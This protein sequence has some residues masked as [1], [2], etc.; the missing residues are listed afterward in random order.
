MGWSFMG[1]ELYTAYLGMRARQRALDVTANNIANVSTTAFK[2]DRLLYRSVEAATI[3]ASLLQADQNAQSA[4]PG[5]ANVAPNDA[6]NGGTVDKPQVASIAVTLP[7]HAR[8]VGVLMSTATDFSPGPIRQTG[9]SLDVALEGDGFLVVQTPRGER[10]TRAGALTLNAN[11]QL[12]THQGDLVVGDA[13]PIT[14]P[15]GEVAI[16]TDGTI[17]VKGQIVGRLKLVRFDDPRRALIKEGHSLFMATGA[18]QPKEAV[19]TLVRSGAL[20][21]SNVNPIAELVAMI[22][23]GRE[24]ESMQRS[25]TLVMGELGR[26]ISNELGKL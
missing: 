19:N 20:E 15:P 2:A 26:K 14:V 13:G 24:F 23:Q 6:A 5:G 21:M 18:E 10:Y 12:V 4:G 1:N 7:L 17:S 25:L 3:E 9:R 11:G 8:A 16:G 22:Q